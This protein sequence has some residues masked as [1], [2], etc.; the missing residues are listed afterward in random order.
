[1]LTNGSIDR[2]SCAISLC[3]CCTLAIALC[4][5]CTL[6]TADC[7]CVKLYALIVRVGLELGNPEWG[8]RLELGNPEWGINTPSRSVYGSFKMGRFG[9]C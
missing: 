7:L 3:V 1:M 5:Y 8:F 9:C 2:L 4:I 6:D